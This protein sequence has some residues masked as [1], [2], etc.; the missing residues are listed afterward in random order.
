[1]RFILDQRSQPILDSVQSLFGFG[2]VT[3]RTETCSQPSGRPLKAVLRIGN[4][5]YR[6]T[7]YGFTRMVTIR[8]Y[9]ESYPLLTKKALSFQK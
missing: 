7:A 4:D 2:K 8:Q 1:M 9:F 5:V 3:L 6:Y